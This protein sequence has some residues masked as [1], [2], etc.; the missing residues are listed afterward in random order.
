MGT[1]VND[2]RVFNLNLRDKN[3]FSIIKPI[4]IFRYNKP[5]LDYQRLKILLK[6]S[7]RYW[8]SKKLVF[9]GPL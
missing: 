2:K 4:T 8:S 3:K 5:D 1:R 6:M 7:A 9:L